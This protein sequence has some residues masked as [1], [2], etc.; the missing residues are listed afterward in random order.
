MPSA[1]AR[2]SCQHHAIESHDYRDL[3]TAEPVTSHDNVWVNAGKGYVD[4]STVDPQTA[5]QIGQVQQL[6]NLVQLAGQLR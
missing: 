6:I 2:V 5:K 1:G 4:V 3:L